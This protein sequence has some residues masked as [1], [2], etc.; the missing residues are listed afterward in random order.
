MRMIPRLASA[1]LLAFAATAIPA[2]AASAVS[3][4]RELRTPTMATE[5]DQRVHTAWGTFVRD[6]GKG[7]P[8][9][10]GMIATQSVYPDLRITQQG[11]TLYAPTMKP[12]NYPC[13]EL[14]TAYSWQSPLPQI[15]AWDWCAD[16]PAPGRKLD[17]DDTFVKTY[18]TTVN[19]HPAYQARLLRADGNSWTAALWNY[20]TSTWDDF[21]TSSGQG[22]SKNPEGWSFFEIY[23]NLSP[24]GI[25][26][27]CDATRGKTFES[28]E[29]QLNENGQ[30]VPA[31]PG[32]GTHIG[33]EP[34]PDPRTF[35]C[36]GLSF[37]VTRPDDQWTVRNPG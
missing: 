30:W 28:T 22:H 24:G 5:G 17:V 16:R 19:G 32:T 7:A 9:V 8:D 31:N 2:T 15:W 13:I 12:P 6:V 26:S 20:T 21:F 34:V 14:V 33:K 25:G 35:Q 4:F 3:A 1:V 36:P 11:E 37:T 29:I 10:T 27:Y 23:S 18:T